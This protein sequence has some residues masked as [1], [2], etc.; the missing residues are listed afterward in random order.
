[1]HEASKKLFEYLYLLETAQ[2]ADAI[3][4]FGHFDL[5]IPERCAQLYKDGFAKQI[6][7]TGGI[8][9]GTADLG[10]PE[11]NVF[12]EYIIQNDPQIPETSLITENKS[13]NTGEN[14][15][16]T[17]AILKEN[18]PAIWEKIEFG[19]VLI[20]ANPFRQRRVYLTAR[21]ILPNTEFINC[22]PPTS[23][24]AEYELFNSKGQDLA[25]QI[26][27]EVKRIMEYPANDWIVNEPLPTVIKETYEQLN[28]N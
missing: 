15:R 21:K 23:F 19:K 17:I 24:E 8:G 14:L 2:Q 4:G 26:P 13:T 27:G 25:A 18:Y 10:M 9:A 16:F 1:M 28:A 6:I 5:K 11:A 20:V 3:I 7:L 12:K 22:P